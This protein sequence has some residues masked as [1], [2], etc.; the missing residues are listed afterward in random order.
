MAPQGQAT[1]GCIHNAGMPYLQFNLMPSLQNSRS[2]RS[3]NK[4]Q[5]NINDM[6]QHTVEGTD[7]FEHILE[8]TRARSR[9]NRKVGTKFGLLP[10]RRI[11]SV[12]LVV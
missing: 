1:T 5:I 4:T 7:R 2:T 12:V 3:S 9:K 8:R 6:A 11:L 10:K